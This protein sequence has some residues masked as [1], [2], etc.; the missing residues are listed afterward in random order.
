VKPAISAAA[1]SKRFYYPAIPKQATLKEMIVKG[2][3]REASKTHAV[4]ALQNVSFELEH[5]QTLGVIGR[6]GS[7]KT[8]LLRILAGVFHPDAGTVD[9]D[10]SLAPL[11]SLGAGFHPDL[12]GRENAR[13]QLLVLGFT[14]R[15]VEQHIDDIIDFADIGDFFDAPMRTYST[16]MMMRVAFAAATSVDPDVLLLDEV[17]FVGDEAF[18]TKCLE[19]ISGFKRR[20]KAVVMVSHS[21]AAIVEHCDVALW[22]DRG[23]VAGFG[24]PATVTGAYHRAAVEGGAEV[25]V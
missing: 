3:F 16:G 7:G 5:G 25:M 23:R 20:G 24:D 6:N 11:L 1:V 21:N 2:W 22:L 8:T 14:P 19:R 15:Q 18:S 9:I 17:L 4:D 13:T 12:T 10:G